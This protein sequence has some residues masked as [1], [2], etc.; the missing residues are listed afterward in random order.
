[1]PATAAAAAARDTRLPVTP[2]RGAAL[3]SPSEGSW[4]TS[5]T[6]APSAVSGV[7]YSVQSLPPSSS[8]RAQACSA[9]GNTR[10]PV[11]RILPLRTCTSAQRPS[12]ALTSAIQVSSSIHALS[13]AAS[14]GIPASWSSDRFA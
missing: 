5:R 11:A 6:S 2:D 14:A 4:P 3:R 13:A 9:L 10:S 12:S 1:M 8:I 7:A